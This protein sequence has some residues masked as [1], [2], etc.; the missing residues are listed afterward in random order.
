MKKKLLTITFWLFA[1]VSIYTQ[2]TANGQLLENSIPKDWT[3]YEIGDIGQI[4]I[5]STLELRGDNSVHSLNQKAIRNYFV[6]HKKIDVSSLTNYQLIFQP[7]G[8]DNGKIPSTYVRVLIHYEKG[9]LGDFMKW[10]D[11]SN[12]TKSDREELDK[13]YKRKLLDAI[14]KGKDIMKMK[15]IS[16]NP[17]EI[18]KT[19]DLAYIK[20]SYTR[21]MGDRPIVKV[22][23]FTF[24]NSDEMVEITISHS[25][26][27]NETGNLNLDKI[28][29]TFDFTRRK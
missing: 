17:I 13:M 6:V 19:N 25:L 26:I 7:L 9:K 24:Y 23:T 28:V 20:H 10:N 14:S 8:Y 27:G 11:A 21:Q 12:L 16:K 2:N 3:L 5:P 29:S 18:G 4:G 22:Q 15:L 1:A